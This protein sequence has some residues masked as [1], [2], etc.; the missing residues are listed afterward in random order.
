MPLCS[1][2]THSIERQL[3]S[4]NKQCLVGMWFKED[5]YICGIAQNT[6]HF[7][8]TVAMVLLFYGHFEAI[9]NGHTS[10]MVHLK[11]VILFLDVTSLKGTVTSHMTSQYHT[12]VGHMTFYYERSANALLGDSGLLFIHLSGS[13]L[14]P[15]TCMWLVPNTCRL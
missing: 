15:E 5:S 9:F 14:S 4:C 10:D 3:K 12:Y 2:D 11:H 1:T 7:G 6:W 13:T 8:C